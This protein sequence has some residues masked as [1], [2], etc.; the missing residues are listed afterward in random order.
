MGPMVVGHAPTD[1]GDKAAFLVN[2]SASNAAR[3]QEVEAGLGD[4]VGDVWRVL[5]SSLLRVYCYECIATSALLRVHY[6]KCIATSVLNKCKRQ[7]SLRRIVYLHV[8]EIMVL[9]LL[10]SLLSCQ[11]SSLAL[12]QRCFVAKTT[13]THVERVWS[14]FGKVITPTQISLK[15]T[16]VITL[17]YIKVSMHLYNSK[18]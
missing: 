7:I 11:A 1:I 16:W 13:G 3:F 10:W 9:T 15:S 6:Y 12:L 18:G 8:T 4:E 5:E 14:L 17:V 2:K